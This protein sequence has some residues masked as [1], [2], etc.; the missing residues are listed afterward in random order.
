MK[1]IIVLVA[2]ASMSSAF[3]VEYPKELLGRFVDLQ[4]TAKNACENPQV[5]IEKTSRF[6]DEDASCIPTKVSRKKISSTLEDVIV[7]EKCEREDSRWSQ[8]A[9][10]QSGGLMLIT[11][12][13]KYQG[14]TILRLKPC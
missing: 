13:S 5:V 8:T 1:K 10:F 14:E 7:V 12:R 6:N 2:V 4:N 3:S 9:V 11:Q